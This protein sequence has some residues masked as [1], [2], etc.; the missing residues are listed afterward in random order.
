MASRYQFRVFLEVAHVV[1]MVVEGYRFVVVVVFFVVAFVSGSSAF[2][3]DQVIWFY[4]MIKTVDLNLILN[5][6]WAC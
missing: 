4:N 1:G 2:E 5:G 6:F 3:G